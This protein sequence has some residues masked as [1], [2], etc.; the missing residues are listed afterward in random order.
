M[1]FR[2]S[3]NLL[4]WACATGEMR[5]HQCVRAR[6]DGNKNHPIESYTL[7]GRILINVRNMSIAILKEMQEVYLLLPLEGVT[8]RLDVDMM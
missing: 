7:F 3:S 5:N 4:S 8:I 6:F 2:E 1:H